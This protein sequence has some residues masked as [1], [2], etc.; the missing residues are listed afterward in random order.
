[1]YA[2]KD[3]LEL[4]G[5]TTRVYTLISTLHAL[6]PVRDF[7]VDED[8]IA[9]DGVSICVPERA[10]RGDKHDVLLD[11]SDDHLGLSGTVG[12]LVE[13]LRLVVKRGEHLMITGPV[14][15]SAR[16]SVSRWIDGGCRIEWRR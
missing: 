15:L 14:S 6:P 5:L 16:T 2:Y 4:A 10:V 1:M 7:I 9:L 11:D 12:S 3:V 8:K 13:P